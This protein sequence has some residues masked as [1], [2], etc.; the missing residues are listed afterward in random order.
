MSLKNK[1]I[2]ILFLVPFLFLTIKAHAEDVPIN[3]IFIEAKSVD[4]TNYLL[5]AD[6]S[7]H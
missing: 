6:I 1:Y 5:N 2:C 4:Y 7:V 3:E